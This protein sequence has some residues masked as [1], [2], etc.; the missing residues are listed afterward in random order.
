MVSDGVGF[1]AANSAIL[2][3]TRAIYFSLPVHRLCL[4]YAGEAGYSLDGKQ[5]LLALASGDIVLLTPA[6][7]FPYAAVQSVPLYFGTR[8]YV[9]LYLDIVSPYIYLSTCNCKPLLQ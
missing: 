6:D 5:N 4:G 2:R 9:A 1:Y 7:S 8:C 3:A